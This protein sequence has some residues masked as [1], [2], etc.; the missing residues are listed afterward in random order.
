MMRLFIYILTG[1]LL[2]NISCHK[3]IREYN[4][5]PNA[6]LSAS[7]EQLFIT[8]LQRGMSTFY[9]DVYVDQWG[10]Q[11]W[12]QYMANRGGINPDHAYIMPG[13]IDEFWGELYAEGL[14][15]AQ[16]VINYLS[17]EPEEVNKVAA[18][19]I[20]KVYIFQKI[21]DIWGDI[22]Y[23]VALEGVSDYNLK[24]KY[25]TQQS[26]YYDMLNELKESAEQTDPDKPFFDGGS[27][28]IYNGDI[29]KWR[30][31]ANSLRF[32]LAMRIKNIDPGKTVEVLEELQDEDMIS[33]NEESAVFPHNSLNKN[34]LF[35]VVNAGQAE[36]QNNPCQYLVDLLLNYN[37]PRISIILQVSSAHE[38]LPFLYDEYKGIPCW[39]PTDHQDWD[40]YDVFD[41]DQWDDI[42]RIGE[43]FLRNETP[44]QVL[45]YSEL[46][47]LKAE[48]AL[49]GNWQG[50]AQEYYEEGIRAN[51][52]YYSDYGDS[53]YIISDTEI[54]EYISGL[55]LVSLENIIT[56][57]W[58]TFVFDNGPEAFAEYR[59]TGYPVLTKYDGT[60]IDMEN[61]PR[62]LIYPY[63]EQIYNDSYEDVLIQQGADDPSTRIWW[64]AE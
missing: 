21:T 26:I 10:M 13:Y 48:A 42:S 17:D 19:R 39:M 63:T 28:I 8:A 56:Q 57:K 38:A 40:D 16:E 1:F 2:V 4:K 15:H 18:C 53:T 52:H 44:A 41:N 37:D 64:D 29:S 30:A 7:P 60:D 6:T 22:P 54:D 47:F 23:S 35:Q 25:D 55:P 59:R 20:W 27:D 34:P 62:R 14:D 61:F 3:D 31:F 45:H 24:P 5:N 46:C 43:W 12:M 58:L 32:K 11:Q 36:V 33:S 50:S 49:D 9:P 51:M